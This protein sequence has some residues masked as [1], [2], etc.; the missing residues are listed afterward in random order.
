LY[1]NLAESVTESL[2]RLCPEIWQQ[3]NWLMHH[4]NT[5]S[6][7][8]FFTK[9]FL[10]KNKTI[11]LLPPYVSVSLIADKIERPPF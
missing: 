4:D 8:S 2:G 1:A 9:E 10:T 5:P 3:K 6:H 11:V 7:T